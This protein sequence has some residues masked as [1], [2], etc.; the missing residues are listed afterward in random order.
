[1]VSLAS[2]TLLG[3]CKKGNDQAAKMKEFKEKMCACADK[4]DGAGDCAKKITD[5]MTKWAADNAGKTDTAA[6]QSDEEAETTKKFTECA[7]KAM[8]AGMGSGGGDAAGGSGGAMAGGSGGGSAA[9]GSG[10]GAM[11]GGGGGDIKDIA[12][13]DDYKKRNEAMLAKFKDVYQGKDCG[14]VAAAVKPLIDQSMD[15]IKAI[16]AYEHAHPEDEN[17]F[18][19]AHKDAEKGMLDTYDACGSNAAF[20]DALSNMPN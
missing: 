8:M 9:A 5:E 14:K 10:G 15:E 16:R 7:T 17:A 18:D 19:D 4:K 2:V 1:L 6:K 12:N 20:K 3:A 13:A 11:A